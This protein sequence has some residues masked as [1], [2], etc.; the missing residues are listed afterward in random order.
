MPLDKHKFKFQ[1]H[2]IGWWTL[3]DIPDN[4]ISG[5][6]FIEEHRMWIEL[7]F[8]PI[9]EDFPETIESLIGC[10][11]GMDADGKEYSAN[12]LVEGLEYVRWCHLE[13]GLWHYKY[14]VSRI[15][16][17]DGNLERDNVSSICIRADI[18]DCWC[19]SYLES[20]YHEVPYNRLPY[21]H[22][23][24]HHTL[25][26]TKT[27]YKN[28]KI[29]VSLFF[30]CSYSIGGI[31]QGVTQ[32]A[33]LKIAFF[34]N[35]S[36][37][38]SM[39][40]VNQILYLFYIL[41]NRIFPIDYLYSESGCNVFFYRVNDFS[42]YRFIEKR[43]N[44]TP[45][46]TLNDFSNLDINL[47]FQKWV[48]LYSEHSDALNSYFENHTNIYTPPSSKIK[49]FISTID[50][51]SKDLP[52][53]KGDFDLSTKRA[54]YL[55][56]IIGKYNIAK[57]DANE[58]KSRFLQSSGV[59]LKVRF[60]NLLKAVEKYLSG[61]IESDFVIKTVN[62]RHNIIHPKANMQPCFTPNE[63][64][65]VASVL[66]QII[67]TYI[68]VLLKTPDSVINKILKSSGCANTLS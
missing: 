48:D 4:K 30:P 43:S 64:D 10:T 18:L 31:N 44:L 3:P 57:N 29:C 1:S 24:I 66:N 55:L 7:Y 60:S 20:S 32:K 68:L 63:Y 54:K 45:H 8:K 36:F 53:S 51:L 34:K 52:G 33:F 13:N 17:Y 23:I 40:Y 9:T 16:I 50:T 49:N 15:F 61:N 58:L 11:S 28:D 46:V 35:C 5:T 2:Y 39:Y 42:L 12:M 56:K 19:S 67:L 62:T 22:H 14:Y 65:K 38:D 25:P 6:L 27:L 26:H 37:Q 41:T 59:E 21:G 47:I